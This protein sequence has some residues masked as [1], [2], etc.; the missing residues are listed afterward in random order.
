MRETKA[1]KIYAKDQRQKVVSARMQSLI[2]YTL[3]EELSTEA[4]IVIA[5]LFF[6]NISSN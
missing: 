3:S 2:I 4:P 5:D 1:K 6:I